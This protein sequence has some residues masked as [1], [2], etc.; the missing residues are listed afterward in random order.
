MSIKLANDQELIDLYL[1]GDDLGIE[2]LINRYKVHV[3]HYILTKTRDTHL[4]EDIFQETFIKVI[5]G[6]RADHYVEK[7]MFM[8]WVYKIAHNLLCDHWRDQKRLPKFKNDDETDIFETIKNYDVSIEEMLV[9]EQIRNDVRKLIDL[10]PDDQREVVM[11]RHFSGMSFKEI[12]EET[13][14]NLNT[15]ISR[16]SYALRALRKLIK[17]NDLI[18]KY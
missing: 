17:D 7:G 18:L 9:K 8:A 6:L 2:I 3:M 1:D 16:M 10:L 4:A 11:M 12:A 14:E 5:N 13:N 15:V